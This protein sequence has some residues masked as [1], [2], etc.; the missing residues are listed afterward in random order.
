MWPAISNT[1]LICIHK[2]TYLFTIVM[3]KTTQSTYV[4]NLNKL[5]QGGKDLGWSGASF[6]A[7][8][9]RYPR[10]YNVDFCSFGSTSAGHPK[11][12]LRFG[13]PWGSL[14]IL[15]TLLK[16]IKL[17]SC[18]FWNICR[19]EERWWWWGG[20][21]L[22]C[23]IFTLDCTIRWS[24]SRSFLMKVGGSWSCSV[25]MLWCW[26]WK[27]SRDWWPLMKRAQDGLVLKV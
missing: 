7:Q 25:G 8:K 26:F 21:S 19:Y 27:R 2:G 9:M 1:S 17:I 22:S 11:V 20:W 12:T 5:E 15:D 6:A 23:F 16:Q 18:N 10:K 13:E 4:P 14:S 24:W 3:I